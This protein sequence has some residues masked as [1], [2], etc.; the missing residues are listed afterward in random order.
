MTK[1]FL[2]LMSLF[3]S[4]A[5]LA[6][7]GSNA[8][9]ERCPDV[10]DSI[11][12][13]DPG[14]PDVTRD[15]APADEGQPGDT[16]ENPG[17]DPAS[18]DPGSA[19]PVCMARDFGAV[20][21]GET[22]DTAAIQ[23]AIEACAGTGGTVILDAG[24]YYSGT[25]FLRSDLT[26]R[27]E[28]GAIL[29]GSTAVED[30]PAKGLIYGADIE[31]VIIEGPGIMD[32]NGE[33]WWGAYLILEDNFRPSRIMRILRARNLTIRNLT[34]RQSSAWHLHIID[35]DN[36]LIERVTIRATVADNML[37]PNTDG[38][39][40]DACR[41]VVVRHCDIECGDDAI[42]LKSDLG[43][44]GPP[45]YDILVHDC[46][47]ASWANGFKIGTRPWAEISDVVFRDSWIR[48]SVDSYPGTRAL[49]GVTLVSDTGA[50]VHNILIENVV[51]TEVQAPF[52][53]RVQ[54]RNLADEGEGMTEAGRLF[55]VTFRDVTVH[56]ASMAG[57]IAGIPGHPVENV[58]FENVWVST[59]DGGTLADRDIV[60][61]QR[62]LEY[63]DAPY[64][65]KM[66]AYGLY[67]RD[68]TGPLEFAGVRFTSL[69][70][71]EERA[72]VVLE[73]VDD[74]DVSGLHPSNEV[75]DRNAP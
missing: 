1:R 2:L 53:L 22:L 47:L 7:C 67:A 15:L 66:P 31:N 11:D 54:E 3:A 40:I 41:H 69:A 13:T 75:V 19:P 32:G 71:V 29:L 64:F 12:V 46:I 18:C 20:G 4:L 36:V 25:I 38:I 59:S 72:A 21:D 52:F 5:M 27:L 43:P 30:Y 34:M 51:M 44:D 37:S 73:D 48:A 10:P 63:P 65:G 24:T 42:V 28:E 8:T 49:G 16:G 57:L 26:L 74:Y 58:R 35:C 14:T 17:L 45:M 56:D 6:A 50:P 61:P 70:E 23:A 68:V 60:P 55:D 39:D 62:N 9:C 33:Y